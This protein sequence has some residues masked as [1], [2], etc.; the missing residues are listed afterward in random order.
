M[1]VCV[2]VC[3]YN[4]LP[5]Y[6]NEVSNAIRRCQKLY[7]NITFLIVSTSFYY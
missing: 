1:C 6:Y 5:M 4:I 3:V 7:V 2:Y